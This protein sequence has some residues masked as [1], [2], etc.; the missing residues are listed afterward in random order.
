MKEN[1]FNNAKDP[2]DDNKRKMDLDHIFDEAYFESDEI[3]AD[4][5]K[6]P[7]AAATIRP[8]RIPAPSS[9]DEYP[10]DIR[11]LPITAGSD[12]ESDVDELLEDDLAVGDSKTIKPV[13]DDSLAEDSK[14]DSFATG[15]SEAVDS[16][17]GDSTSENSFAGIRRPKIAP[18]ENNENPLRTAR[19]PKAQ[20]VRPT[21]RIN[22]LSG[23]EIQA[24]D[25]EIITPLPRVDEIMPKRSP[26][27]SAEGEASEKSNALGDTKAIRPVAK[28]ISTPKP[29]AAAQ[30][31]KREKSGQ[32]KTVSFRKFVNKRA[33]GVLLLISAV[34]EIVLLMSWMALPDGIFGLAKS[35]FSGHVL[36]TALTQLFLVL[37]PSLL[38]AALFKLPA[39]EITGE[40]KTAFATGLLSFIIGIPAGLLL[41][42][43]NN[44]LIYALTSLD[45]LVP[46]PTLPGLV[47]PDTPEALPLLI[48]VTVLAPAVF[49]EFMFRG[50]LLP[51]LAKSSHAGLSIAMSA[52]AFALFHDN[53]LFW[54]APLGAGF[55]LGLL[56][57][58]SDSLFTS[59]LA[60]MSMN[61]SILFISPLIPAFTS[62]LVLSLGRN[63]A[64]YFYANLIIAMI[65]AMLLIPLFMR[66]NSMSAPPVDLFDE[67]GQ[68]V[69]PPPARKRVFFISK[70]HK[71]GDFFSRPGEESLSNPAFDIFYWIACLILLIYLLGAYFIRL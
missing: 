7:V 54:L 35:G 67:E 44:I 53:P 66:F 13:A 51:G 21:N 26:Q 61:L 56:R 43:L 47:M 50:I 55:I 8:K 60:H 28:K 41:H 45:F 24:K 3:T 19:P 58:K 36:A 63:S 2:S 10:D 38:V 42:A 1:S 37:L 69:S 30:A 52:F 40:G 5:I 4:E 20:I 71:P 64:G 57:M 29:K 65:M 46:E 48:I 62:R 70:E 59:I 17:D 16:P 31:K 25:R 11:P 68:I 32:K 6:S 18:F 12:I 34:A 22:P 14:A 49:E 39:K 33:A 27:E 9:F 15:E 23:G